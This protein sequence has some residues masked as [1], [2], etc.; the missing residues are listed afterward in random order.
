MS[1]EELN[2]VMDDSK[3]AEKWEHLKELRL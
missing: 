2:I 1:L 3:E